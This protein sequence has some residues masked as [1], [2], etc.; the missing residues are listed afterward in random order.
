M[1]VSF[2]IENRQFWLQ[3]KICTKMVIEAYT[4]TY[5][6]TYCTKQCNVTIWGLFCGGKTLND[7]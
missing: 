6:Y 1:T 2:N 5:S 4:Y 3:I 7:L